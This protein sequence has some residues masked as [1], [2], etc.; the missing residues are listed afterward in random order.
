[1]LLRS[2]PD[3]LFMCDVDWQLLYLNPAA[4]F[5]FGLKGMEMT[6]QPLTTIAVLSDLPVRAERETLP[7]ELLLET[8]GNVYAPLCFPLLQGDKVEGWLLLLRDITLVKK[9]IH[10]QNEFIRLVTH[11]LRTP[12]TSVGGYANMLAHNAVGQMN[13]KQMEFIDKIGSGIE[14]MRTLVENIQDANRFDPENG[15]YQMS[16]APADIAEVVQR[17]VKNYL[18]PAEKQALH[19][20]TL[21]SPNL[22]IINADEHM[23]DRA[24]TNLIDNAIKYTPNGGTIE[25]GVEMVDDQLIIGVHD[26]GY[27][28]SPDNQKLIFKRN[29]RIHRADLPRTR[30]SGLGLFIVKSAAQRHGGEAWVESEEGQGSRFYISLPL[31]GENLI[32]HPQ[33]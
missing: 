2:I 1:M 33:T 29:V 18:I 24:V 17:I 19:L 4:E 23:I 3:P 9:R 20:T 21:L 8:N 5:A 14:Y 22:P 6:G 28:I 31:S 10:Y 15:F 13:P 12:L 11:D 25:V 30:G 27:G 16:R 26:T 32:G 7:A